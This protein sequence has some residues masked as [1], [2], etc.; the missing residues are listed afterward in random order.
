MVSQHAHDFTA[1]IKVQ[2]M[3]ASPPG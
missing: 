1:I 3:S 2:P